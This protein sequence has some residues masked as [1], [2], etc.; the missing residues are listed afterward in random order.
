[1]L[2]GGD[3]YIT[4][5]YHPSVLIARISAV[6][7]RASKKNITDDLLTHKGISLDVRSWKITCGARQAEL[8]KNE[9]RLLQYLLQHKGE[10]VSRLDII[11]SLWDNEV[12]I[13]DNALSVTVTR[14]RNKLAEL[15]AED[16]IKTKRGAGYQI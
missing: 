9:C 11:E 12:Y 16:F 15:G 8:T 10:V 5:P 3:D 6:L 14:L 7:K 2:T 1:L 13:D 4:K